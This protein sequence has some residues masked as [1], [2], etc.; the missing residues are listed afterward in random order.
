M[1]PD[2]RAKR[3]YYIIKLN[4]KLE[5]KYCLMKP[6]YKIKNQPKKK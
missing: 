3:D 2:Y 4:N 6:N 1:R 5:E